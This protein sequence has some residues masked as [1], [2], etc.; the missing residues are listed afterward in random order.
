[1]VPACFPD[2]PLLLVTDKFIYGINKENLKEVRAVN[3][4]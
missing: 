2:F 3:D 1:M 4:S